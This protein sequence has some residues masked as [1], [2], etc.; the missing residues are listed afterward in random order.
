[1]QLL[2]YQAI[3][4]TTEPHLL[5]QWQLQ[6]W[7]ILT[8]GQITIKQNSRKIRHL[9]KL[10]LGLKLGVSSRIV[11]APVERGPGLLLLGQNKAQRGS[12]GIGFL[13]L[14]WALFD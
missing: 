14:R 13:Y 5:R 4:A 6:V 12:L 8:Y 7:M 1:M 2:C 3:L 10:R 9:A 11:A